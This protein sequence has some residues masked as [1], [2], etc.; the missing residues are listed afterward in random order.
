MCVFLPRSE[1][2]SG[3]IRTT[4]LLNP[5]RSRCFTPFLLEFNLANP[6][7]AQLFFLSFSA[8]SSESLL[9]TR[10]CDLLPAL[11]RFAG[12]SACPSL[13]ACDSPSALVVLAFALA[14]PLA[15]AFVFFF[16]WGV[17]CRCI[18]FCETAFAFA[19]PFASSLGFC[20]T[21]CE[22]RL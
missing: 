10:A 12:C 15:W 20:E 5:L 13:L 4:R 9:I 14:F 6:A 17:G 19:L 16:C 8:S 11:A 18:S 22:T 7:N 3:R 1:G 2:Q 21:A